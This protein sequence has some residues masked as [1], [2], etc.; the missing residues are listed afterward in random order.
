M[1]AHLNAY[2]EA[3][4]KWSECSI[5]EWRAGADELMTGFAKMLDFVKEHMT[6]KLTLYAS[7]HSSVSAHRAILADR[8]QTLKEAR[9]SLV[10]EGGNVV[11]GNIETQKDDRTGGD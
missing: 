3:K 8:D 11:G 9:E 10:R 2:D 4:K 6:T 5:D 7:L 1:D